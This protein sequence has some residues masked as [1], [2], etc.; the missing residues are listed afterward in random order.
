[1]T[2]QKSLVGLFAFAVLSASWCVL[3]AVKEDGAVGIIE[4]K[5]KFSECP[6]SVQK[7]F[8]QESGGTKIKAVVEVTEVGNKVYKVYTADVTF[9]AR[10]Y[11]IVAS[12]DG[13]LLAK[14]RVLNN[15]HE[16]ATEIKF[17]ACPIA[18]Q[19]TLKR[20]SRGA[21]IEFVDKLVNDEKTEYIIDSQI[22]D[23]NYRIVV[24]ENGILIAK[25]RGVAFR[26]LK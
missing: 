16:V 13:T 24:A 25:K 1:M 20:E 17:R 9:D 6:V 19:K 18:V 2:T 3:A 26:L 7:T 23:K 12:E 4:T 21:E 5:I 15:D 22:E 11:Q 14:E 10:E 8:Q